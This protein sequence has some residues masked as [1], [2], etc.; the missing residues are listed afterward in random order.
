MTC[1]QRNRHEIQSDFFKDTVLQSFCAGSFDTVFLP[2]GL[3]CHPF[4]V[5]MEGI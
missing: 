5:W 2:H 3:A 4:V 1:F